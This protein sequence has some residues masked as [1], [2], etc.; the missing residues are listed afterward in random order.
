MDGRR[1]HAW[2]VAL[3]ARDGRVRWQRELAYGADRPG[4]ALDRLDAPRAISSA[5]PPLARL[6]GDSVLAATELGVVA[7]VGA[8]DGRLEWERALKRASVPT[9]ARIATGGPVGPASA[10]AWAPGDAT[11]FLYLAGSPD[12]RPLQVEGLARVLDARAEAVWVLVEERERAWVRRI[13]PASGATSTALPLPRGDTARAARALGDSLLVVAG[14]SLLAFDAGEDPRLSAA[15]ELEDLA[16]EP[17]VG[18]W[19]SGARIYVL[20]TSR[21]WVVRAE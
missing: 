11:P 15:L 5:S 16:H 21:I 20:G 6:G 13:E 17:H 1:T 19:T 18:L 2:L 9:E 8:A 14:S 4:R 10:W 12:P 7:Q 3:D